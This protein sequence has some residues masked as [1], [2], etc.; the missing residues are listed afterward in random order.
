MLGW[1]KLFRS[2][3]LETARPRSRDDRSFCSVSKSTT[4]PEL[5]TSD[6]IR[7][8]TSFNSPYS[9]ALMVPQLMLVDYNHE[10]LRKLIDGLADICC[11]QSTATGN[12]GSSSPVSKLPA[13]SSSSAIPAEVQHQLQEKT[14]QRPLSASSFVRTRKDSAATYSRFSHLSTTDQ[15]Y[16]TSPTLSKTTTADNTTENEVTVPEV[17]NVVEMFDGVEAQEAE[18]MLTPRFKQGN[19]YQLIKWLVLHIGHPDL[20][21]F[22][23][24]K[25]FYLTYKQFA[26]PPDVME[27]ITRLYVEAQ[28]M[29][30]VS[31]I[32]PRI[33]G[34]LKEWINVCAERDFDPTVF[35]H[36]MEF[37]KITMSDAD[38]NDTKLKYIKFMKTQKSRSLGQIKRS[39]ST[40]GMSLAS[41]PGALPQMSS[42]PRSNPLRNSLLKPLDLQELGGG[43]GSDKVVASNS[44]SSLSTPNPPRK[45]SFILKLGS[46]HSNSPQGLVNIFSFGFQTTANS[47]SSNISAVDMSLVKTSCI[48]Q[49][50]TLIE[51]EMCQKI[52]T[53]EFLNNSWSGPDAIN[54]SPNLT[55]LAARFN[56]ISLWVATEII[57]VAPTKERQIKMIKKFIRISQ[58][59]LQLNN[60]NSMMQVLAG[61]YNNSVDRLKLLDDLPS[62][63]KETLERLDEVVSPQ[64]NY[65][66]LRSLQKLE[67]SYCIPA[68]A[69]LLRDLTFIED[70]NKTYTENGNI[71]YEKQMLLAS[72]IFEYETNIH[73]YT[74]QQ[75]ITSFAAAGVRN[76]LRDPWRL[77][78]DD[79]YL[80]SLS[81]E[82]L[83][84]PKMVDLLASLT[85]IHQWLTGKK[86]VKKKGRLTSAISA[87]KM[88]HLKALVDGVKKKNLSIYKQLVSEEAAMA[89]I[90]LVCEW[91]LIVH[92]D[93]V[94]PQTEAE[95]Q[96]EI[97]EEEPSEA[98]SEIEK[99]AEEQMESMLKSVG[100]IEFLPEELK[101]IERREK[102]LQTQ[103]M[104]EVGQE[105]VGIVST[106]IKV[107]KL[108]SNAFFQTGRQRVIYDII[109]S[110]IKENKN[111]ELLR[112]FLVEVDDFARN[113]LRLVCK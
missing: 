80:Y 45:R 30:I 9:E 53:S 6:S 81:I 68:L 51:L 31:L 87:K 90:A 50:L 35:V 66:N 104:V 60:F 28:E 84:N 92:H 89:F 4:A 24:L 67:D 97:V 101:E 109:Q 65:K 12:D 95:T 100:F 41:S 75:A 107:M 76:S 17:D 64:N 23:E 55:N 71:N 70:G 58:K 42:S 18:F 94:C 99:K 96:E 7:A 38:I 46:G 47:S 83:K 32:T 78:A 40:N 93:V 22:D 19:F 54:T 5:K 13:S 29:E 49:E 72:A 44:S 14:P 73:R 86:P 74:P 27:I 52:N 85:D 48:A 39:P 91:F 11:V 20:I 21:H 26:S 62:K 16:S 110:W 106:W 15:T 69:I 37:C 10:S 1:K 77:S 34:F 56:A 59:L 88:P 105:F 57:F 79:L 98:I 63:Y 8:S 111:P 43:S 36:V 102:E 112:D 33:N 108:F 61:I 82:P 2:P 113:N 25:T 3:S 103:K